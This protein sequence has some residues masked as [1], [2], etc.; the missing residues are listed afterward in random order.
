M[1]EVAAPDVAKMGVELLSFTIKDLTDRVQY[2]DSLGRGQI[3]AV[4]RDAEIGVAEAER[5][6]GIQEAECEEQLVDARCKVDGLIAESQF[7]FSSMKT[8]YEQEV[9]IATAEAELAFELQVMLSNEPCLIFIFC[10]P[11]RSNSRFEQ[12]R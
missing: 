7:E 2:L 3:A 6:A 12:K 4:R 10:R 11:Q 9:S 8:K 5:D 1:R